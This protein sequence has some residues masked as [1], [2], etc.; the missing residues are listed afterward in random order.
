VNNLLIFSRSSLQTRKRGQMDRIRGAIILGLLT[1]AV[2]NSAWAQETTGRVIGSVTDS[3][4]GTPLAGVTVIVQGPQG[5]DA[6]ITDA[7]GQYLFTGLAV[8][9]YVVRYFVANTSTQVERPGIIV[10]A[11]KTVR[12]N[13]K[14]ASTA[15]ANAQQTYVITG[16]APTVDVGSPRIGT[17]FDQDF[18]LNLALDPN[19]GAVISKAPGAFV[20]GSGNVSIGGATG[21]ENIYIVNGMNVTGMRYGNLDAG[22]PSISGGT[23]LP[24]EFLTQ[25]DVNAGGYQAEFGGAMGGVINTVLKS[26][27]NEFHGSVF[28]SW[29]PYWLSASPTTVTTLGSSI[30]GAQKRDF[31]DRLGFEVGGPLI[32]D[33]LFFWAGM[34]PQITDTHMLRYTYALQDNGMGMPKVDAA[35][36][37][38]TTFLPNDTRRA[39]ET[40]RTY[41]YAATIDYIP[42]INHKLEVSLLGTPSFNNN[43]RSGVNGLSQFDSAFPGPAGNGSTTWAQESLTRTNTDAS[44]HWTSKFFDRHWQIDALAGL[45]NEYYYDRSPSSALNSLNQ[46]QYWGSNLGALENLPGCAVNPVDNFAPCPVNPVYSQ[47]GFGEITKSTANRWTGDLKSTHLFEAGGRHEL[48]YGWHA[49][50]QTL[51]ISRNYSGPGPGQ[52]ALTWFNTDGTLTEQNFFRL[53]SGQVP[54]DEGVM[55]P[56]SDLSNPAKGEYQDALNASVKSLSD[57]FFLQDTFSPQG[58]RNLSVNAG[59]RYEFQ[60]LYDM[61]GASFIDTR[62][63]APRLGVVYDPFND[64]RSKI[65]VGYGQFYEAIPLD[66]AARYYGGENF[67]TRGEIPLSSCAPTTTQASFVGAG[68]WRN[69]SLGPPD[70]VASGNYTLTNNGTG[71]HQSHIQGQYQNEV[72]ATLERQIMEDMTLRVDYTHRWLGRIVEDV[73]GDTTITDTL[74]NPGNVP[75][76]AITDAQ[77]QY[78]TAAAMAAANPNDPRLAANAAN[79]K[80]LLAGVQAM[81]SDPKPERTYDALTLTLNK[82]FSKNWFVRGAYTYSRLVGNYEGLYQSEQNY[83][84]PNGTNAYDTQDIVVNARGYLSNDH[85]HQGKVDGYYSHEVGPGKLTVGLSFLAR[86]GMPRNDMSDLIPGTQNVIVFLLPRGTA[87]RT[88]TTTQLDSHISYSQKIQKGVTAEAFVDLFNIFDERATQMTDDNYTYDAVAPIQNGTANDLKF[89]KN[90]SGQAVAK[91][92]NF[93]RPISYQAPFYSRLGLRLMF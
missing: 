45:H 57:A 84:A 67:V 24:T 32:K 93:G 25:I 36:N 60:T 31:D 63:L 58:L 3:D 72:V 59:I 88:P 50:L 16:K 18:T 53:K 43:V 15:Q 37:P 92:A 49:E 61:N 33:K 12:V 71:L 1:F 21:L 41:S 26:G 2:G 19:Y 11:E 7:K 13:V 38:V 85:P 70:P 79:A 28:G 4:T 30:A 81:A 52:H 73:Y 66:M 35:G 27:S 51:D 44:A 68:E 22:Q 90:T 46:I 83:V 54:A 64:G 77:N 34:A 5:E 9:T 17:T 89:A 74:G 62:N 29:A 78:N 23:N 65:S 20:D 91:N 8:G 6:T 76:Q 82:R 55:F 56:L 48:K 40:H 14:I 39:N 42:K 87:G 69:C 47:G 10:S 80:T 86:S 75:A